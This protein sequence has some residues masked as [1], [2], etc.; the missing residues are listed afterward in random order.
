MTTPGKHPMDPQV[1]KKIGRLI[2]L[3]QD[4]HPDRIGR[5]F[6]VT[7]EWCRQLWSRMQ[8]DEMAPTQEAIA[9]LASD[10]PPAA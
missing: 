3:H 6:G 5:R 7:G 10:P 4:T 2:Q 1:R 8:P 9:A